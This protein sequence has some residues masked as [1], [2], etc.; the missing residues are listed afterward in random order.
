MWSAMAGRIMEPGAKADMVPVLVGKGGVG[1]STLVAALA[2]EEGAFAEISFDDDEV[3]LAR[4]IRGKLVVELGELKGLRRK[5]KDSLKAWITK[6]FEEW[7]P[8]Y[9]EFETRYGRRC[10][11]VGTTNTHDFLEDD[12]AGNRRWLPVD[13]GQIRLDALERDQL[14]AEGLAIW[15]RSG[16]DYSVERIAGVAIEDATTLQMGIVA[17]MAVGLELD[18]RTRADEMRIASILGKLGYVKR[19]GRVNGKVTRLYQR[20]SNDQ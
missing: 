8:K 15:R 6:Q 16:V 11:F 3:K 4:R 17:V 12:G 13:V 2:P 1:K 7:E 5:E 20:Q 19:L 18:R 10:L 14:W 9:Q